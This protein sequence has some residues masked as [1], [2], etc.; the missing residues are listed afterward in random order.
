MGLKD[1]PLSW[2]LLSAALALVFAL[3]LGSLLLCGCG[4]A[5]SKVGD[6]PDGVTTTTSKNTAVSN[7]GTADSTG[8]TAPPAIT[9]TPA[10]SV[11][12]LQAEGATVFSA[13]WSGVQKPAAFWVSPDETL[14]ILDAVK[15]RVLVVV[16]GKVASS[17][18][19]RMAHP[20][21]VAVASDGTILVVGSVPGQSGGDDVGVIQSYGPKGGLIAERR[22]SVDNIWADLL[23]ADD[24]AV[25]C[26]LRV[27]VTVDQ[28][29]GDYRDITKYVPAYRGGELLDPWAGWRDAPYG[30]PLSGGLAME[31]GSDPTGGSTEPGR[32]AEIRVTSSGAPVFSAA[33]PM[34]D[35]GVSAVGLVSYSGQLLVN[36]TWLL[37]EDLPTCLADDVWVY[38]LSGTLLGKLNVLH[39]MYDQPDG[40]VSRSRLTP[41]GALFQLGTTSKGIEVRRYD[42]S[43]L[44]AM[45]ALPAEMPGD[46]SFSAAYGK[47]GRLGNSIDT[48]AGI[49][50]RDLLNGKVTKTNTKLTPAQMKE[51]YRGLVDMGITAYDSHFVPEAGDLKQAGAYEN[52]WLNLKTGGETFKFVF[53]ADNMGS[54]NPQAV[55]LRA[56]FAKLWKMVEGKSAWHG[57]PPAQPQ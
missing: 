11:P 41:G 19:V 15:A 23:V 51:I 53:W 37:G 18:A 6:A 47:G 4:T 56:W 31:V 55:A 49:C 35:Y 9:V 36:N 10:G 21:D 57:V 16:G 27:T 14:Y 54:E 45:P 20:R 48:A 43:R 42:L 13:A 28:Q 30:Q 26:C 32:V 33:L 39:P 25:Y 52:Y 12:V 40:G 1:R 38:S 3:A 8:T 29:S 46:F 2:I 50:T 5:H 17:I 22:Q 24:T 44:T 34:E 7:D